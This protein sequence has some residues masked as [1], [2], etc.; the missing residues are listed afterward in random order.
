MK[1]A[2]AP[3]GRNSG[4]PQ[5]APALQQQRN[6]LSLSEHRCLWLRRRHLLVGPLVL[7][8]ASLAFPSVNDGAA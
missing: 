8:V 4:A 5:R 3:E 7:V 2:D 1:I 6:T